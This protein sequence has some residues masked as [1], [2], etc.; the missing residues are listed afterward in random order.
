MSNYF[1]YAALSLAN[2]FSASR[3]RSCE[4]TRFLLK[5]SV[6]FTPQSSRTID[7]WRV[8]WREHFPQTC[9]WNSVA[10][11]ACLIS[12]PK[13]LKTGVLYL[14]V[15]SVHVDS[16]SSYEVNRKTGSKPISEVVR[17]V[18]IF[19]QEWHNTADGHSE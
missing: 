14:L 13:K 5:V 17:R 6:T 11:P 18:E 7:R 16:W 19:N 12:E 1:R 4:I 3:I 15:E 10:Q 9:F 2:S 8:F